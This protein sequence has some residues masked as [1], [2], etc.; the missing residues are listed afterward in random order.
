LFYEIC[1]QRMQIFLGFVTSQLIFDILLLW[2]YHCHLTKL[3][4]YFI[5]IQT[6]FQ[7]IP[8]SF[9]ELSGSNRTKFGE[10]IQQ[11]LVLCKF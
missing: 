6:K 11:S 4:L 3:F 2:L 10:G 9:P 8:T 1:I 5:S 7:K